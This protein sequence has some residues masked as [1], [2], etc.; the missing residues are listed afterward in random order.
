MNL[1][2]DFLVVRVFVNYHEWECNTLLECF[3][4]VF[5]HLVLD[6]RRQIIDIDEFKRHRIF[7][8]KF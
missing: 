7:P 2:D 4:Q 1:N 3:P 8:E 6:V 5:F